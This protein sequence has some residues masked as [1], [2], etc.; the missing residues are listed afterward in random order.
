M[1]FLSH[2][3]HKKIKNKKI[4]SQAAQI[5]FNIMLKALSTE[6]N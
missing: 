4:D 1:D 6:N 2:H 3:K 5:S